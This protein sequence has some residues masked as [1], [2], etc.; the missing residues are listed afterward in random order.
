MPCISSF[1]IIKVVFPQ[2][3]IFL[4]IPASIAEAAAVIPHGSKMFFVNGAAPFINGPGNLLNK[5]AKNPAD[6]IIL[7]IW[8]LENFISADTLFSIAF[9]SF[10]FC[11][12]V[13][14]N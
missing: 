13:N 10:G 8:A 1:E 7:D 12:V 5:N 14:N 6:W 4:W 9:L 2:P 11:L 3:W